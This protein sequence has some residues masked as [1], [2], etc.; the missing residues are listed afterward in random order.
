MSGASTEAGPVVTGAAEASLD[1]ALVI[2]AAPRSGSTLLF[3][4]LSRLPGVVT[5]GGESHGVIEGL[6]ALRPGAGD[7]ASNRLLA[8]DAT[9][10]IRGALRRLFAERLKDREGQPIRAGQFVFL[11]KTPKNALR[12]PFL[13]RVLPNA[14]YLYLAREP[15]PN[16]ASMLEAWSSGRFVTYPRLEGWDGP[17]WSLL[18]PPGW[19]AL[20]GRPVAE[21]CGWQW[22]EANRTIM[23][24]LAPLPADRWIACDYTDLVRHPERTIRRIAT[25]AGLA[26][27]DQALAHIRGGLPHSRYTQSAPDPQKW[28]RHEADI[29]PMMAPGHAFG[30]TRTWRRAR[31]LTATP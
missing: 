5:I 30:I 27:D 19:A 8:D 3:E 2:L 31:R 14:R 15:R 12:V 4:T 26:M 20:S 17:P 21:I 9:P 1:S 29:E 22:T 24:D 23:D 13:D 16:I 7:R 10:A 11:E 18:L 25:F 28:R 6:A